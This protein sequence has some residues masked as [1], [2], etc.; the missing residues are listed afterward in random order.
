VNDGS[1]PLLIKNIKTSC[2]CT[3]A[4]VD[5]KIFLSGE[6]GTVLVTVA[7]GSAQGELDKTIIVETDD[8]DHPTTELTAR[9]MIPRLVE[10]SPNGYVRWD[11]NGDS[12]PQT[13]MLKVEAPLPLHITGVKS[14]HDAVHTSLKEVVPGKEY[15]IT[16]W[17]TD[18]KTPLNSA[19]EVLNDAQPEKKIWL[20]V[21]VK[22]KGES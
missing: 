9:I 16:V 19:I 14:W 5:K 21:H 2:G 4:E 11:L 3:T 22:P 1:A 10:F 6:R 12:R 8:Q 15:A 18:T 17:P 20:L 7:I 13:V